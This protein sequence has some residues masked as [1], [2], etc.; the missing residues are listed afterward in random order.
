MMVKGLKQHSESTKLNGMTLADF[1]LTKPNYS[2][3]KRGVDPQ[4]ILDILTHAGLLVKI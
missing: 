2:K 1:S 3:L 4:K